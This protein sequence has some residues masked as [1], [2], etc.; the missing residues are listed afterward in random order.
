MEEREEAKDKNERDE[1]DKKMER[2]WDG[3]REMEQGAVLRRPL[4]TVRKTERCLCNSGA[5]WTMDNIIHSNKS[6]KELSHE[7]EMGC[8]WY[9]WKEP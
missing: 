6:L 4:N 3:L 8:L 5:P 7:I 2:S 1:R 9:G